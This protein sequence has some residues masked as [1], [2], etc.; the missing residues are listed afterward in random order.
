MRGAEANPNSVSG[1]G[2]GTLLPRFECGV[3]GTN[4]MLWVATARLLYGSFG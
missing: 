1:N 2:E 3:A 4:D